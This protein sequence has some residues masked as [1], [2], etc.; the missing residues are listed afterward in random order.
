MKT[1]TIYILFQTVCHG[2]DF[3]WGVSSDEYR[4]SFFMKDD[5][6]IWLYNNVEEITNSWF[7]IESNG[8]EGTLESINRKDRF[9]F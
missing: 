9:Y 5:M 6:L 3:T 2:D 8:N 4:G 7:Y 1:K